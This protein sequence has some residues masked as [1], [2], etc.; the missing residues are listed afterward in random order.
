MT[1][2]HG[3]DTETSTYH[4]DRPFGEN[5]LNL[6][7]GWPRRLSDREHENGKRNRSPGGYL[8]F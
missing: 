3:D 8:L 7:N 4:G 5:K 1:P 6:S 2:I